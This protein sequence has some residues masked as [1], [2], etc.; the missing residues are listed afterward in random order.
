MHCLE[1]QYFYNGE[2]RTCHQ[3]GPG[4]EL[5]EECGYGSG[6]NAHCIHCGVRSY[7]EDWGHH[8][9]KICLS[10]KQ[11]NR[12]QILPCTARRNTVCGNCLPGFYSKTRIDGLQDLECMP[13]GATSGTE[14]RCTRNKVVDTDINGNAETSPQR[15]V[16]A[17]AMCGTVVTMAIVLSLLLL[18]C[19]WHALLK[20]MFKVCREPQHHSE[21]SAIISNGEALVL[22]VEKDVQ[23]SGFLPVSEDSATVDIPVALKS[24]LHTRGVL[25]N[26]E[27]SS[28]SRSLDFQPLMRN[29]SCSQCSAQS[30]S[31]GSCDS[32]DS[33]D[34]FTGECPSLLKTD[35][36]YCAS[37]QQGGYWHAPIECTELDF[38]SD[39]VPDRSLTHVEMSTRTGFTEGDS[40]DVSQLQLKSGPNTN[41]QFSSGSFRR[42]I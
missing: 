23:L 12:Q 29:S 35:N 21:D 32:S 28:R 20:K 5:S 6:G 19:I 10:C 13:C 27:T 34:C 2:C 39:I 7:K 22:N 3:C 16:A 36:K 9:C 26:S 37:D 42:G 17:I 33:R 1:N 14:S 40:E 25:E 41:Q 31:H 4:L 24:I 8:N 18:V 30:V 38:R 15:D 11:L